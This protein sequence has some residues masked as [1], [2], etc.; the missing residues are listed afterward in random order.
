MVLSSHIK[1]YVFLT[2]KLNQVPWSLKDKNVSHLLSSVIVTN[3]EQMTAPCFDTSTDDRYVGKKD[4][5]KQLPF[6]IMHTE[7]EIQTCSIKNS[8][9]IHVSSS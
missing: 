1:K 4:K 3:S 9:S 2:H 6:D 8:K 7:T 5:K